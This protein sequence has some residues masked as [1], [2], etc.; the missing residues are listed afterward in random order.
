MLYGLAPATQTGEPVNGAVT[1]PVCKCQSYG[2]SLSLSLSKAELPCTNDSPVLLC[3]R[4]F[5]ILSYFNRRFDFGSASGSY[6]AQD[7]ADDG[8]EQQDNTQAVLALWYAPHVHLT[9]SLRLAGPD[10]ER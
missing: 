8:R 4:H 10:V 1:N 7:M 6:C 5:D 2:L 9:P 3:A